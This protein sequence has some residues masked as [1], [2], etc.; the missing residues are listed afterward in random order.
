MS[1]KYGI[2][3]STKEIIHAGWYS[4]QVHRRKIVEKA[5]E[6]LTAINR[7]FLHEWMAN[8]NN[9]DYFYDQEDIT[10]IIIKKS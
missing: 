9:E 3:D 8:W 5:R 10:K 7:E 6:S 1:E 4:T 2:T